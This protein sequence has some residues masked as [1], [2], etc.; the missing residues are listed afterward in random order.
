MKYRSRIP[1]NERKVY[2]NGTELKSPFPYVKPFAT[3]EVNDLMVVV[4]VDEKGVWGKELVT[5]N[6]CA[7]DSTGKILWVIQPPSGLDS[8]DC[9]HFVNVGYDRQANEFLAL[10]DSTDYFC[11]DLQTGAISYRGYSK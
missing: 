5:C 2:F 7:F 8:E 3:L 9:L 4:Y 10:A 1:D 11:L 6:I